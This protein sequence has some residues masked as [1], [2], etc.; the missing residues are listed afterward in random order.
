MPNKRGPKRGNRERK[1]SREKQSPVRA[2]VNGHGEL[3]GAGGE[4]EAGTRP[5]RESDA[6]FVMEGWSENQLALFDALV[7]MIGKIGDE[8][9]AGKSMFLLFIYCA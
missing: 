5:S 1:S 4:E 8:M 2:G 3:G 6:S 9:A 7:Q